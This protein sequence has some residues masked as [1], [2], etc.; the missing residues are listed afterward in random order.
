MN[1]AAVRALFEEAFGAPC[2]AVARAPGRVNLIGEHT[3]Y[4]DG[5]VLPI[6][7]DRATWIAARLR[8]DG[9]ARAVSRQIDARSE[10]RLDAWDRAT[11]PAWTRYVHGVAALLRE[12]GLNL[13]GFDLLVWSDVPIGGGLSSSAALEL[14]TA[15]ALA[16]LR[17]ESLAPRAL[18]DLARAAEHRFA[19]VPCGIMD[20]TA[21]A[22]ATAG[23]ALLLDCRTREIEHVPCE[24]PDHTILII[25]SGVHHEL[26]SGEYAARQADCRRAVAALARRI[27]G[28]ASLRDVTA[29]Q[30][31]REGA[32]LDGVARCRGRHVVGEIERTRAA[33]DA[34]R[35]GRLLE[36][37]DLM[38]ASHAS[39]RDDY[40]VSC[41]ELDLIVALLR[42]LDGVVGVR[43]TG[44]GF[45]GC[46]VAIVRQGAV[47]AVE[48]R[49]RS[50]YDAPP[51]RRCEVL[52]TV[53]S[54]GATLISGE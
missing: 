38:L 43:M 41:A 31:Q 8:E 13:P 27:P 15:L 54:G 3:D 28:L 51:Q 14:S 22:L 47:R 36:F 17:G 46:A 48:E 32:V 5:F 53:A 23:A 12:R 21:S 33:A 49:L 16:A 18:I 25:N 2:T 26:A 35:A 45:G 24:L 50:H 44:G 52:R 10:W 9:V 1:E 20:Q 30:L 11:A 42:P 6:A 39:L 37:G 4:N 7:I 29:A 34:L 19:E 40:E